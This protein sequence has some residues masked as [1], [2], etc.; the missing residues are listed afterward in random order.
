MNLEE[1]VAV[2]S[3]AVLKKV[4][5]RYKYI[6]YDGS[7]SLVTEQSHLGDLLRSQLQE[8]VD[9]AGVEI[10]S[11]M[12]S[13]LAYAPE[14]ATAMLQRQQAAATVDARKLVVQGAVGIACDALKE[15]STRGSPVAAADTSR[16]VSNL[17]MVICAERQP[18]PTIE[19]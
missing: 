3:Q 18:V 7:P 4:A 14:I 15:L 1:Y 16:F 9:P 10:V 19:I 6:T 2:Q 12:L 8:A 13:D 11:F 17:V 5:S